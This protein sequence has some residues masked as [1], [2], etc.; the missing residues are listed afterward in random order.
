MECLA[1]LL[2]S[3][4]ISTTPPGDTQL[5]CSVLCWASVWEGSQDPAEKLKQPL[6]KAPLPPHTSRP[7][8]VCSATLS[9]MSGSAHQE[10]PSLRRTS[11]DRSLLFLERSRAPPVTR[12]AAA[13]W[14]PGIL[15]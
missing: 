7:D 3:P 4:P 10:L 14:R 13:A 6:V 15:Y 9:I 12:I 11:A 5:V 2:R 1:E 8:W